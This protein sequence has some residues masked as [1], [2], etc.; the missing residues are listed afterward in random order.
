MARRRRKSSNG[1]QSQ[2]EDKASGFLP[3]KD[4]FKK[5][6]KLPSDVER[7]K[8]S[9]DNTQASRQSEDASKK[10]SFG[11]TLDPRLNSIVVNYCDEWGKFYSKV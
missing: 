4:Q 1:C 9:D 6:E 10:K 11:Q 5:K 2:P 7:I 8:I 3:K